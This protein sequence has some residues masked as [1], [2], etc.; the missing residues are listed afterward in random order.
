MSLSPQFLDEL[1]ARTLLSALVGRTVKLQRAGREFR[2]CCPFHN[3]KTPSFYVNDDKGFYHC[4]GCSAHGDAIRW[5]TDHRGL[6]FI[7]AVREL[8]DAA[9]MAMP[10][11]D[12][13]AAER[14]ERASGLHDVMAAASRWFE[15]QLA[16]IDGSEA[17]AYLARRGIADTSRARFALG[18]AP[19]RRGALRQALDRFGDDLLIEAGL[20]ISV[21]D[22]QPYDRF[23]GRLMIPIRDT[24]GRVIAFGG[25]IIGAKESGGGEPKYLNSPD[26]PLFDKGRTLY[27]LDL[28]LTAARKA[29]RIIVVEG[30]LDVIALDAAGIGEAVAPLGT[31]LT[32]AQM[33]RLWRIVPR[34]LLCFDGDSAGQRAATRAAHRALPLLTPGN[35]L[36]FVHLPPGQD[37]DDLLRG[38]GRAALDPLLARP[39]PLAERL[40][41]HE[42]AQE[43]ADTPESRA[44]LRRRLAERAASIAD[45][46]VREQYQAEFRDRFDRHF[47]RER[48][49]FRPARPGAWPPKPAGLTAQARAM[50][51][52][53]VDDATLN[54]I[55]AGLLAWPEVLA[56]CAE[57]L[58]SLP[59]ADRA[60]DA[61]RSA[62]LDA[63]FTVHPLDRAALAPILSREGLDTVASAL[64]TT[65]RLAFSFTRGNATREIATRDLVLAVNAL[66]ARPGIEAALKEAT[67]RLGENAD[68]S[69]FAEQRRL[70]S[71]RDAADR[72]LAAL[73]RGNDEDD[74]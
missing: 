53:A 71:S 63:A 69:L 47:T 64:L 66:A 49:P 3:E 57:A 60:R 18:F 43:A 6:P 33:E 58:A 51:S 39:E 37:P 20:M 13:Q 9:G 52:A 61:L 55:L 11:P 46:D 8:A 70:L 22:K 73:A 38:G 30:Y 41:R 48:A 67:R 16:G 2:A 54:A 25:R 62:L 21:D 44:G 26:T 50:P 35:S 10:A 68:D 59:I 7:D 29:E 23:R 28:A 65:N 24:R 4:F 27:N 14:A 15:E 36:D 1:R 74:T 17:R 19:D 56:D 32:E 5:L 42:L 45:R 72:Q 34:P 40:W 31:A 12:R